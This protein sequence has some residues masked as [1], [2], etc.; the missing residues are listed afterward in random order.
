MGIVD[1]TEMAELLVEIANAI[2]SRD[3]FVLRDIAL[4]Y[5]QSECKN[6]KD[7][8]TDEKIHCLACVEM[9]RFCKGE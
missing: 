7:A 1:V 4:T 3:T 5:F 9:Y 6:C 8:T 2:D